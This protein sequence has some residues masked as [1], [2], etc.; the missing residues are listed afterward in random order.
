LPALDTLL[1]AREAT[2]HHVRARPEGLRRARPKADRFAEEMDEWALAC[3]EQGLDAGLGAGAA[4]AFRRLAAL[5]G[6]RG[7]P[8]PADDDEGF[9]AS[10]AIDGGPHPAPG[11]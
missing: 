7:G 9:W 11:A 6:P 5:L 4:D 1:L 8:L 10:I 3:A 2:A